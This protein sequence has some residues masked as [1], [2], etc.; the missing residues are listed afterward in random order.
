MFELKRLSPEAVP[1]ALEKALRY[2]TLDEPE[3]AESICLDVL[4]IEPDNQ[5]A[6]VALILAITD[7]FGGP[8]PEP[9]SRAR[10][11]LPRLSGEY[12]RAYYEGIVWERLA[13]ARLR[14]GGPGSGRAAYEW[15]REAMAAYERA[16]AVRPAANDDA[17]LRWNSCARMIMHYADVTPDEDFAE[18]SANL[19][20]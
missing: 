1:A 20:E 17:I 19:G 6:L 11:L 12:E 3:Q 15:F 9:A 4:E 16:E 14:S 5:P 18:V 8:R 7:R 13:V 2:R 10:E